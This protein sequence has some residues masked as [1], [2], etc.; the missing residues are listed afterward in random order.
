MS[1]TKTEF[2]L[3]LWKRRFAAN[4]E[5]AERNS[6]MDSGWSLSVAQTCE[7]T[8]LALCRELVDAL[9]DTITDARDFFNRPDLVAVQEAARFVTGK[10]D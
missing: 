1:A 5:A 10:A 4:A 9:A 3:E 6:L 7:R 8:A 2:N